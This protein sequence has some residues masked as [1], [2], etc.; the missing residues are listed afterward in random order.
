MAT[1]QQVLTQVNDIF[2]QMKL[3]LSS[4]P[5]LTDSPLFKNDFEKFLAILRF[6]TKKYNDDDFFLALRRSSI[7]DEEEEIDMLIAMKEACEQRLK[8]E[9]NEFEKSIENDRLQ[10]IYQANATIMAKDNHQLIAQSNHVITQLHH[11]ENE[12][13]ILQQAIDEWEQKEWAPIVQ[14]HS[15][16]TAK[17]MAAHFEGFLQSH[18]L[19][20]TSPEVKQ[21]M[22][23]AQEELREKLSKRASLP[24]ILRYVPNAR[25]ILQEEYEA[26]LRKHNDAEKAGRDSVATLG[27]VPNLLSELQACTILRDLLQLAALTEKVTIQ[28]S[29]IHAATQAMKKDTAFGIEIHKFHAALKNAPINYVQ[30]IQ[31]GHQLSEEHANYR[32]QLKN[33]VF[34][35]HTRLAPGSGRRSALA[36]EDQLRTSYRS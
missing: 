30:Y 20:A 27:L 29:F 19:E 25:A 26:Q 14:E 1:Q 36:D 2:R 35:L 10:K 5:E 21:L 34:V 28:G 33:M 7:L 6:N 18:G 32:S 8:D 24:T 17:A 3:V 12:E 16:K 13:H 15:Q 22:A 31:R 4:S 23:D 9:E 11:L